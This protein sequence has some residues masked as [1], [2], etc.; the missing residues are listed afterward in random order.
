[1]RQTST[2][3]HLLQDL[4]VQDI[5]TFCKVCSEL[6]EGAIAS[7]DERLLTIDVGSHKD[8]TSIDE[9]LKDTPLWPCDSHLVKENLYRGI[10]SLEKANNRAATWTHRPPKDRACR[11]RGGNKTV[12]NVVLSLRGRESIVLDGSCAG[13]TFHNVD[14]RGVSMHA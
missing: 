5:P 7:F 1:M 6:P 14:T 9:S 13:V 11:I 10:F 2:Q 4:E 8:H 3:S 12:R